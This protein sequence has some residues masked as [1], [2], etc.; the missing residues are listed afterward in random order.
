MTWLYW[1]ALFLCL[2]FQLDCAFL[3]NKD[4]VSVTSSR[5]LSLTTTRSTCK[6]SLFIPIRTMTLLYWNVLFLCLW[7]QLG[8]AFLE[9]WDD[10]LWIVCACISC[11][12]HSAWH[13]GDTQLGFSLALCVCVCMWWSIE[14]MCHW[15]VVVAL[16]W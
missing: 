1:N 14:K 7:S 13:R 12:V 8:C 2:W 16:L 3:E 4:D 10:G 6:A 11:S 9:N 15:Y 5:K